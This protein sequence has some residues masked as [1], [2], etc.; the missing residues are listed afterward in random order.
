M[1]RHEIGLK[2]IRL[3]K[4]EGGDGRT[5]EG[6][7]VPF[8]RTIDTWEGAE[9]FDSDC[10]FE[11]LDEAKLCYQHGELIGT[12]TQARTQEDGL[13]IQ[14]RIADTETGRDVVAL[15]DEGALDSL[16]IGFV[17]IEDERDRDGITHRRKVRLLETSLVSWPAY[18]DAKLTDHR[19]HDQTTAATQLNEESEQD[20]PNDDIQKI[21]DRQDE[22]AETLRKIQ[23]AP[24]EAKPAP[25][26]GEYRDAGAFLKSLAIGD[27][28]AADLYRRL[29]E[30]DWTGAG[31]TDT[32]PTATWVADL[33]RILTIKRRITNLIDHKPLPA[34]GMTLSYHVLDNDTTT[35]GE[36]KKEGDTLPYGKIKLG[37]KSASVQTFGGYTSVSRQVIERST[38][39]YLS[40]LMTALVNSYAK[41]SEQGSR[42][43]LYGAIKGVDDTARL[44]I[45]KTLSATKPND[46]LGLI[47]DASEEFDERN[48]NL[49]VLGVSAD[50]FKTIASLTD[51]GDRFMNVSGAN[52]NQLGSIDVKGV[53]GNLLTLEV[54]LLPKADAGTACFIDHTA[55]T[56][57]ESPNAPFRLQQDNMLN[58][59]RDYSVYGYAAHGETFPDGL[60][61]VK[62]TPQV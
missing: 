48:A 16:S 60:L 3:R 17:P 7:A 11:G 37:D 28:Q 32:D 55:V 62:F 45:G 46:W 40:T 27:E 50:V 9:T 10:Q 23:A 56:M 18:Q 5:I 31:I 19:N 57:W 29:Q 58:L 49:E 4:A 47:V 2:G 21:L 44:S 38:T 22:M 54:R 36:Q 52:V 8:N 61:P 13:H 24:K 30:R 53:T 6:L 15:L 35:T 12:I 33:V 41:N 42:D 59:T 25:I 26:G 34:E 43:A 39:D 20:M 1:T 51:N 14:A